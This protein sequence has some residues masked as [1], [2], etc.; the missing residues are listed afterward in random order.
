MSYKVVQYTSDPE[1]HNV[2]I[3]EK[4]VYGHAYDDY[5]NDQDWTLYFAVKESGC[6]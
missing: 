5:A 2:H 6:T 3:T 4:T 1:Y